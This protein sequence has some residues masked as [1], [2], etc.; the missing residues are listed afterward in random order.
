MGED[1][2]G[3]ALRA[4]LAEAGVGT[5]GLGAD[6]DRPTTTKQNLVGLAQHRHPQKMFRLDTE[7]R[8]PLGDAAVQRL[9]AATRAAAEG[10]DAVLIEDYHKGVC[11]PDLCQAIIGLAR[12]AGLPVLV[13]PAAINDY[14]RYAGA[15]AITPN[16]TEAERATGLDAGNPSAMAAKLQADHGFGHVVLTLDR[17]GALLRGPDGA[18]EVLPTRARSV[19]DVT[20]AGDMVLAALAAAVAQGAGWPTAVRLANLAAGLEVEKSGVVPIPF[21]ELFLEVLAEARAGRG[22][23]RTL[24]ELL[25][26]LAAHRSRGRTI[27]FTNGC[28][29]VLHAGH[30]SY[31]RSAAATADLLVVGVNDDDSIRRLKGPTRPVNPLEDRL[32]VLSELESVAWVV[33]F[34]EDTPRSLIEA[35]RPSVLVKGADY[36]RETVVGADAVEAAGGRVELVPLV[37]G[38]STT[39]I[40]RRL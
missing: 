26:E 24:D 19:Y 10:A 20:G 2:P 39:N 40:L 11:T 9:L 7:D 8:T 22:K 25:P 4:A 33:P 12:E 29:D 3:R 23:V 28:F 37:E 18:E 21:E 14:A 27:G 31:L 38:R 5:A 16:R 17:H 6:G 34:A 15:D 35:I 1:E 36:T 32:L 13:D 30:V